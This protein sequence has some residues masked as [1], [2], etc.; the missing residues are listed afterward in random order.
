MVIQPVLS[1]SSS[2]RKKAIKEMTSCWQA[3]LIIPKWEKRQTEAGGFL[4][5]SL[6]ELLTASF[7][8]DTGA[9]EGAAGTESESPMLGASLQ[10]SCG[11]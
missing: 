3:S 7:P 6:P 11:M 2:L 5:V 1:P 10:A 9:R 8:L 4:Q